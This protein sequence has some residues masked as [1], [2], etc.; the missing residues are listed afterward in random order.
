MA[1][2]RARNREGSCRNLRRKENE[3]EGEHFHAKKN[4]AE[5]RRERCRKKKLWVKGRRKSSLE[6]TEL[7]SECLAVSCLYSF[8]FS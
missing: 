1:G 4:H 3:K 2:R 6:E 5:N 7:R 8:C